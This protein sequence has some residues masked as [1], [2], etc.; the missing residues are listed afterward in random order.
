MIVLRFDY[1]S[2]PDV[3]GFLVQAERTRVRACVANAA[4]DQGARP[5][6][7]T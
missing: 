7:R 5:A 4:A 3:T 6:H 2:W 1:H